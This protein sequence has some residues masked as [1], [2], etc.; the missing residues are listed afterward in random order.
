MVTGPSFSEAI[1]NM[2]SAGLK[3]QEYEGFRE[4][5]HVEFLGSKGVI[6]AVHPKENFLERYPLEVKFLESHRIR[7]FMADGRL[8]PDLVGAKLVVTKRNK[9]KVKKWL[10]ASQDSTGEWQVSLFHMSAEEAAS[11]FREPYQKIE[12]SMVECDEHTS[13]QAQKDY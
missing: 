10:W 2:Q 12:A 6:L 9:Q 13:S 3:K 11:T 7:Y 1:K 4:G 8:E 5:D